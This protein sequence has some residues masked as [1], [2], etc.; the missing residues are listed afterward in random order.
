MT[1]QLTV[2]AVDDTVPG[3]RTVTLASPGGEPLPPF[4]PGSH[5]VVECGPVTN[6]YSLTG[7]SVRPT[8][9]R[10]SVLENVDGAGGSRWIH[11]RKVGDTVVVRPPR[12]AFP[13]VL[14]ARRHLMVAAGI[15][16]T[17][18]V[19]HLRSASTWGRA[20][21]LMYLHRPGRGAHL[22]EIAALT[23]DARTYTQRADF[24]EELPTALASQP[25]GTHLYVCGPA[26]FIDDVTAAAVAHGW[27]QSRIHVERFG[28][29]A[30]DPGEPF[31]VTLANSGTSLVV[32]SGVSLLDALTAEG[33]DV[34]N[35]CRQG[36]CGEC[37]LT[38]AQGDVE[39]RDMYLTDA[40]REAGDAIMAC[41]SRAAGPE[42]ELKL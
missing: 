14:R 20:V 31:T 23:D 13:P 42:L 36:V 34:P 19:S 24:L 15:G 7:D 33:H 3:V 21:Q 4:T 40:D 29:G 9:Y 30:L 41:V 17:P 8:E 10:I 28:V 16:I 11:A 6:A 25:F 32:G 38:V 35:L 12:S 37:R 1:L 2:T 39:H 18:F 5:I 26:S 22:D 27:P